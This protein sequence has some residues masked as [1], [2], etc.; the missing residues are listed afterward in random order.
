LLLIDTLTAEERTKMMLAGFP[1]FEH[2]T[3]TPFQATL[4]WIFGNITMNLGRKSAFAA[5]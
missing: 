2:M 1:I 4:I 3:K 5:A